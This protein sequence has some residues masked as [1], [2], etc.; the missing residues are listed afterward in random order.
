MSSVRKFRVNISSKTY[1]NERR[2]AVQCHRL[3]HLL[4]CEKVTN[5]PSCYTEER[6]AHE[7]SQESEHQ[8]ACYISYKLAKFSIEEM[9]ERSDRYSVRMRLAM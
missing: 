4:I 1:A 7:S 6:R 5:C 9:S 3:G 2:A 8:V